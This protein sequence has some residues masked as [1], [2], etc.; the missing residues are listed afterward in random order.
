MMRKNSVTISIAYQ[1]KQKCQTQVVRL[2]QELGFVIIYITARPDLQKES[3]LE[4]LGTH[5]F[6]HGIVAFSDGISPTD[7]LKDKM[8]YLIRL[9]NEVFKF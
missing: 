8:E 4:W 2:W 9:K 3:V 5:N 6:P 7:L 1:T